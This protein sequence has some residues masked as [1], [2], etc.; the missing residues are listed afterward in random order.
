MS[1]N[2]RQVYPGSDI[3][4][5]DHCPVQRRRTGAGWQYRSS[6]T[7][8]EWSDNEPQVRPADDKDRPTEALELREL[9]ARIAADPPRFQ[10]VREELARR[11]K[12][13]DLSLKITMMEVEQAKLVVEAEIAKAAQ[14]EA[15]ERLAVLARNRASRA[16]LTREQ[17]HEIGK[18]MFGDATV[19]IDHQD[20][21]VDA[22]VV[23]SIRTLGSEITKPMS[24]DDAYVLALTHMYKK[25]TAVGTP[26][27]W[28]VDAV[29][30]AS[31]R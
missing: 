6:A 14:R 25:G 10:A 29:V 11:R 19:W 18:A 15:E 28:V 3:Q 16:P 24:R 5:C 2:W 1:H 17:A 12:E 7:D 31:S 4:D 23:A 26:E 30:E 8:L 22:M 27:P 13:R 9:S 20:A 21:V